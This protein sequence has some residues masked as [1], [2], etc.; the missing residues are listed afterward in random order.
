MA[1][2]HIKRLQ[3]KFDFNEGDV[4]GLNYR[5]VMQ[6][7]IANQTR[8]ISR[9]IAR[10]TN[11]S[12]DKQIKELIKRE[13]KRGKEKQVVLPTTN[14]ILPAKSLFIRKAAEKGNYITDTLRDQLTKNLRESLGEFKTKTGEL[15]FIRRRG[16]LAGTINP[17]LIKVFEKK[18]TETFKEY[19]EIDPKFKVPSNIRDIAVT[20]IRAT[21][22]DIKHRYNQRLLDTNRDII[23]ME[24][25]WIHNKGQSRKFRVNHRLMNGIRIDMNETFVVPNFRINK[26]SIVD[27]GESLMRFPHDPNAPPEQV[28]N[29]N[30]ETKY[31]MIYRS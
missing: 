7:I 9:S 12:F 6:D 22:D 13:P 31:Y 4:K 21:I 10:M 17:K 19:T 16:E 5:K 27:L 14:E 28:I 8:N 29:C 20:E 25:Q 24:K 11:Q 23:R 30:C 15:G 2:I 1:K 18:I 26:N 3:R